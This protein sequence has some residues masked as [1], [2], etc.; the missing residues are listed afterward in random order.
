MGVR[1]QIL[2]NTISFIRISQ[3]DCHSK[4]F[5]FLEKAYAYQLAPSNGTEW[6]IQYISCKKRQNLLERG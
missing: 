5:Q 6:N 2:W 1:E 4:Y 3:S